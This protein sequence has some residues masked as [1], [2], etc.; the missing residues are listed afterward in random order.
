M[1]LEQS[2][3]QLEGLREGA[4]KT[5]RTQDS[6]IES[7]RKLLAMEL[8]DLKAANQLFAQE[9]DRGQTIFRSLQSELLLTMDEKKAQN[10]NILL[11][12]TTEASKSGPAKGS[13]MRDANLAKRNKSMSEAKHASAGSLLPEIKL[14]ADH[15][16]ARLTQ[17]QLRVV[18]LIKQERLNLPGG[19][20]TMPASPDHLNRD[21]SKLSLRSPRDT[22]DINGNTLANTLAI[23]PSA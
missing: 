17:R 2:H 22:L 18:S 16:N 1:R 23:D 5:S 7:M 14:A 15:S 12:I 13:M 11:S 21:H 3:Q 19:S 6:Q 4:L 8:K 20:L 10:E 9:I